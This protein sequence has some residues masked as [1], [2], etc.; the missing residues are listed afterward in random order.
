M[1]VVDFHL[2]RHK[3][4]L[5]RGGRFCYCLGALWLFVFNDGALC[6]GFP[7]FL[8]LIVLIPRGEGGATGSGLGGLDG[9]SKAADDFPNSSRMSSDWKQAR[10]RCVVSIRRERE[11]QIPTRAQGIR[12]SIPDI[13]HARTSARVARQGRDILEQIGPLKK[14]K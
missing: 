10:A 8:P 2:L 4:V 7:H 3:R 11:R 12:S 5:G 1:K 14:N 9:P 13:A 6:W